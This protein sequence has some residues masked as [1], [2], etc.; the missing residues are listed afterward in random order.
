MPAIREMTVR[1]KVSATAFR[2]HLK[3][4]LKA[5]KKDKV[6]LVENRRQEAKYLV[7]KNWLDQLIRERESIL[8]TLEILLDRELTERLMNTARTL[9]EDIKAGRLRTVEEVFG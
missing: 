7:D 2:D 5:A 9:D 8:A 1:K 3:S 6:V 4:C